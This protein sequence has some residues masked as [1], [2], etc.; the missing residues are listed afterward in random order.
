MASTNDPNYPQQWNLQTIHIDT[1]CNYYIGVQYVKVAIIDSGI[2]WTHPDF[3]NISDGSSILWLNTADSWS[4]YDYTDIQNHVAGNNIDD[5]SNGYTDD[6]I[7][8]NFSENSY[9]VF[10]LYV[11]RTNSN[12]YGHG[13][14]VAS[15]IASKRNNGQGIAG[16]AG[17]NNSQSGVKIICCKVNIDAN[18]DMLSDAIH[19][20]ADNGASVL[21]ISMD[22][23]HNVDDALL[24]A[25]NKGVTIVA[26]SGNQETSSSNI[27]NMTYPATN[28]NVISVGATNSSNRRIE[29]SKYSSNL[30]LVAPGEGIFCASTN[31]NNRDAN[32]KG[33]SFAAA[34]VSGTIAL[35]L[36]ANHF[37]T[38][39]KI[40][41]ILHNNAQKLGGYQ[42]TNETNNEMG[43]GILDAGASVKEAYLYKNCKIQNITYNENCIEQTETI[44]AG[45]NINSS[46]QIGDVVIPTGKS[47]NYKA[48][49]RIRL[50][51]GFH[52]CAGS[53]FHA[54]LIPDR[55]TQI[56]I[57]NQHAP[58]RR[59]VEDIPNIVETAKIMLNVSPNPATNL[60]T[61]S[62]LSEDATYSIYNLT[63]EKVR[64]TAETAIDISALPAGMYV[65]IA[66]TDGTA[67][68]SKFIKE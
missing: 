59:R 5:D 3:G 47:V 18:A 39:T 17:G 9:N 43:Y 25:I 1:A 52:A 49:N 38:P 13:T 11:P 29:E 37:L 23:R 55:L 62:G 14:A 19:Y 12:E 67:Y 63:G 66:T 42:Y 32:Y 16:I 61:I 50:L 2:D 27:S 54:E 30:D 40:R 57:S 6:Y 36:S 33:T 24:Y 45:R 21:N 41:K 44:L 64:E 56:N 20:A 60:I 4:Y 48:G 7:G 53:N 46:Q 15:I 65:V 22:L 28:E 34:Q 26:S 68:Q 58:Q 8:W 31:I 51:P 10:D 35:M